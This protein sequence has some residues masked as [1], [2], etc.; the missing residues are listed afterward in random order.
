MITDTDNDQLNKGCAWYLSYW[1]SFIPNMKS[2]KL[3]TKELFRYHCDCHGNLITIAMRY[4]VDAYHPKKAFP[5]N[6][7]Y[8]TRDNRIIYI[9]YNQVTIATRSVVLRKII[10][11]I[12]QYCLRQRSYWP[13]TWQPSYHSKLPYMWLM[14][15]I[16]RT[17]HTK[18]TLIELK[19]KKLRT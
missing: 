1:E 17:L 4:M 3:M 16:L 6:D 10:L 14:L 9:H 2:I 19:T 7:L 11:S 5:K 15:I 8:R 13:L 12:T 18:Y